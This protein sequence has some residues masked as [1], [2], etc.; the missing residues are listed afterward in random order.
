L[1]ERSDIVVT[2]PKNKMRIAEEEARQCIQARGGF[3]FRTFR[4]CPKKLAVGSRIFY[5]EDGFVRGFGVVSEVVHGRMTCGTTGQDWGLGHHAVMPA[6]SWKWIRP[7]SMKG[8]QGWRYFSHSRI[9]VVGSW[10]DPKPTGK[11]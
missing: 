7:V 11:A 2:T 6:D 4:N 3:Y 5:V 8:F 1:E 10:L 9:Q